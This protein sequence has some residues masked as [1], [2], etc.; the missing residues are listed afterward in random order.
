MLGG[1]DRGHDE[2]S[3]ERAGLVERLVRGERAAAAEVDAGFG[4]QG[5]HVSAAQSVDDPLPV[6]GALHQAGEAHL[7]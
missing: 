7:G 6:P 4:E 2:R 3:N 1:E 5:A